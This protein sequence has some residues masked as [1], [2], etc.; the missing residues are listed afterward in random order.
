MDTETLL[1]HR[2]LWVQEER[3][4]T[5]L[6]L[7]L[8]EEEQQVYAGLRDHRWGPGVRLEQERIGWDWAWVRVLRV[9]EGDGG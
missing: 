9:V 1:A 8:T 5:G 3:P 4:E 2:E 7:G 6:L